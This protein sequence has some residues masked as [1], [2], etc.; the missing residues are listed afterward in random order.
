VTDAQDGALAPQHDGDVSALVRVTLPSA[1]WLM[2][3]FGEGSRCARW[4]WRQR[5]W[6]HGCDE[7]AH[8]RKGEGEEGE[9]C[10]EGI[11]GK[12][13]GDSVGAMSAHTAA[14]VRTRTAGERDSSFL[15]C[16]SEA[17]GRWIDDWSQG[18]FVLYASFFRQH[19]RAG[20]GSTAC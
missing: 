16:W 10:G 5:Q 1:E 8:R 11:D 12:G 2:S 14:R 9:D 4:R 3:F 20:A 6:W 17:R 19:R 7:R 13:V 18:I 15:L